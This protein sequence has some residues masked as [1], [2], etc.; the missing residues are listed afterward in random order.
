MY[1]CQTKSEILSYLLDKVAKAGA[2]R[3]FAVVN[4]RIYN[5]NPNPNPSPI[6]NPNP[7]PT[8]TLTLTPTLTLTLALTLTPIQP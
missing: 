6:P 8:L 4:L 1:V 2:K 3:F 7:N 5:P